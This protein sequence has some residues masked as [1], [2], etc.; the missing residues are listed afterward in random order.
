MAAPNYAPGL[1]HTPQP[2]VDLCTAYDPSESGYIRGEFFPRKVVPHNSDYIRG[3]DKGQMLR[4]YDL[5]MSTNGIAPSVSVG[6]SANQQ[7]NC[8]PFA[9]RA[10]ISAY[11]T[12]NADAAL[13]FPMR[14]TKQALISV[15]Q[16]MEYLAVSTL[17]DAAVITNNTTLAAAQYWDNYASVDSDPINDLT[18]AVDLVRIRCGKAKGRVKVSMHQL[19]WS[20]VKQHPNVIA[21]LVFTGGAGAVLTPAIFAG[22]IGLNGPEDLI[23]TSAQYTD[24]VEGETSTFRAFI[25][26]DTI[27]G[28]AED[29][30]LDD[31]SLGHEFA[32][33]GMAGDDPFFVR[34]YR[35]EQEGMTG[36]DYVQVATSVDYKVTQVD[37]AYL[38][39][40]CVDVSNT[41]LYGG[42]LS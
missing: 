21:R 34:Q 14:A 5:T 36:T 19:V 24:S 15:G 22:M 32:F 4:L 9:A 38:I 39:K 23:I 7:Y 26:P 25:G 33:N 28:F 37:A 30:G 41:A 17:R 11:D 18:A 42:L 8:K 27:V 2:L 20:R 16:R 12:A 31:Y 3:I 35:V 13:Q 6:I 40:V 1:L 29:G 10:S